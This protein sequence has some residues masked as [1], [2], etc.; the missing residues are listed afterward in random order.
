MRQRLS[1]S[2]GSMRE[3]QTRVY[4]PNY[5]DRCCCLCCLRL[6]AALRMALS[7]SELIFGSQ[8]PIPLKRRAIRFF[9]AHIVENRHFQ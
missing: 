7:G 8:V 2:T 1:Y 4:D 9:G 5:F 6:I 3:I